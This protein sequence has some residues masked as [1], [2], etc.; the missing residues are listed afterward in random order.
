M[1]DGALSDR[2]WL[3]QRFDALTTELDVTSP[4]EWAEK[5]RYLPPSVTSLPGFYR[6]AVAPYMREIVD[7]LGVDSP[8]REVSVMKG[9]QLGLTVGV[10][11]NAIG[12][13]IDHVKTAPMMLVTADAELAKLR[14]ESYITP[15]LQ[16]SELDHLIKSA[17]E[18][19]TRKTGKTDK[20][21]EWSGGGFLVP[22][23]AVNANKLR[24]ISIQVMLRD[25]IDG[26]PDVVGK[27]GDPIKLSGDRTAAYESSRKILD[28]STPLIK[29][30]SKV[31]AR[32]ARGDQRYYFVC[33]FSCG[34]S[35]SL[36]WSN[37]DPSTGVISGITWETEGGRLV[38]DS[39]RYL[40]QNCGHAHTNDDL[41]LIPLSEPKRPY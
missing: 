25:E 1:R 31:T 15:M 17:D 10:L 22:F 3:A 38:Q 39:V 36:R 26:W 35:Q 41:S 27:D 5:R 13:Y 8:I 21:L 34:Y 2:E 4:S 12:Y 30:S 6:F 18:K 11:E 19:N 28:I 14:M 20:K 23:G 33:C 29:G 16:Y 9:V 40:C 24:S 37:T 7:C 32:F